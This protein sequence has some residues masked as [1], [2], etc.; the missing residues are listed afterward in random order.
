M[1]KRLIQPDTDADITLRECLEADHPVSFVMVSGAGSGKTTSL[2]KALDYLNKSRGAILKRKGQKIACIT[3][4]EIAEKEILEDIGTESIF[5]VSTI[6]SFLWTLVRPF[7]SEIRNWIISRINEKI[8]EA[9]VKIANPRTRTA[10]KLRIDVERYRIQLGKVP[11]VPRFTYSMG[12]DYSKGILGHDDILKMVTSL[13]LERPLFRTLIASRF[14]FVFVDESQDTAPIVIEALKAIDS[15]YSDKFCLGFFGDPM[16]KIYLTGIGA[17]QEEKKWIRIEKPEN[18]RCPDPVLSV[19]NQIRASGDRL[20]QIQGNPNGKV[21]GSAKLFILPIDDLR[22]QR[23]QAV[24]N[25]IAVDNDDPLWT[26]DGKDADIRVLVIVHRMAALRLG[27]ATLYSAFNDDSPPSSL[28]EGFLDGSSWTLTPFLNYILPLAQAAKAGNQ[29]DVISMLRKNSP[30]LSKYSLINVPIAPILQGLKDSVDNLVN[31]LAHG[32]NYIIVEVLRFARDSGLILLDERLNEYLSSFDEG[33]LAINGGADLAEE[34]FSG[35]GAMTS[36]FNCPAKQ[37]WAYKNYIED[38]SPYSTQQGIKGSEFQRVLTV[39]DDDEGSY[40]LFSYN[41]Y[42]GITALS[43]KDRENIEADS[44]SV[45]DRT[46]RLF[47][48]SCSRALKDLVVVFFTQDIDL[49]HR[50]IIESNIFPQ[51]SICILDGPILAGKP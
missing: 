24:R 18:F 14:P 37:I 30:K 41:K 47:Y 38:E 32:N 17:I 28:K 29:F 49:A 12:S 10:D 39:L 19:I 33:R 35:A 40:S 27:F 34:I 44:D 31:M 16:Q 46:R 2:V 3:Y 9:E 11:L 6:H 1:S 7:Q 15:Y 8:S 22:T 36:F 48:V 21:Q 26:T 51:E 43:D 45:L 5:H 42:F 23:L 4:T 13:I 50:K 20:Q 25:K